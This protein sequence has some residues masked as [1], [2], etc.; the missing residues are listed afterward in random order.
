[1]DWLLEKERGDEWI[2]FW[3]KERATSGR[4]CLE[5]KWRCVNGSAVKGKDDEWM[6]V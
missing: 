6:G 1:M 2:G 3:R 5:G 4:E